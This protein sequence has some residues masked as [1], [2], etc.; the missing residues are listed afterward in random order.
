MSKN[1]IAGQ[2]GGVTPD[3][4]IAFLIIEAL[5]F[6]FAFLITPLHAVVRSD[7]SR[8][9][10]GEKIGFKAEFRLIRHTFFSKV[11]LLSSLWAIWSFFYSGSWSTYLALYFS[12]R[13]RA[14]SSLIS[15]FFCIVGW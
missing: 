4:Y 12:V 9:L 7:G 15:P 6:P 10:V 1:H 3:T 14:L 11:I 2:E 8:I 5:A 13:A